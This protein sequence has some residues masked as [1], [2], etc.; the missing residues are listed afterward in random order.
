MDFKCSST[1]RGIFYDW[2]PQLRRQ[3]FNICRKRWS[4][5]DKIAYFPKFEGV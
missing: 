3:A 5:T 1:A 2:I 4:I